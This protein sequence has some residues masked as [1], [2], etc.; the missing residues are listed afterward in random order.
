MT[1][2]DRA[3]DVPTQ[4]TGFAMRMRRLYPIWIGAALLSPVMRPPAQGT[5]DGFEDCTGGGQLALVIVVE[6]SITRAS[7]ATSARASWRAGASSGQAWRPPAVPRDIPGFG[8]S[9][10][11][12]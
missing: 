9:P 3:I 8:R 2:H 4:M 1:R 7:L 6:D 5:P 11:Q 12:R 10:A